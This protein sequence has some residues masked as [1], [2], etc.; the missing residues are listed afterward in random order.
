MV[1]RN[2]KSNFRKLWKAS[3]I[4]RQIDGQMDGDRHSRSQK[5]KSQKSIFFFFFQFIT[6]MIRLKIKK[7]K[8]VRRIKYLLK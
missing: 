1:R 6:K 7:I 8:S 4:R 5:F 2:N 3:I